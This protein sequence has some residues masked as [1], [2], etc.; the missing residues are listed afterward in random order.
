M[1]KTYFTNIENIIKT[2]LSSAQQSVRIAVAWI[3]FQ[4]YK[5]VFEALLARHVRLEILTNS[6]QSNNSETNIATAN[7]LKRLGARI[8]I[9]DFGTLMH[10]KFCVI[11]EDLCIFGA[12][13]WTKKANDQNIESITVT[14][15]STAIYDY[16][17]EFNSLWV[18]NAQNLQKLRKPDICEICGGPIILHLWFRAGRGL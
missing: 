4:E 16:L 1:T 18:L 15:E 11:D 7:H 10:H 3:N 14:D 17:E 2:Q 12:F 13:N 6:I 5:D 8:Q 9:K